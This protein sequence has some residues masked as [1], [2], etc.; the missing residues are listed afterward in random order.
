MIRNINYFL[1]IYCCRI[2][3]VGR[4][5]PLHGEGRRFKSYI[6]HHLYGEVMLMV[7]NAAVNRRTGV[8]FPYF[9]PNT[10]L[11]Q[12]GEHLLDVQKVIGSTPIRST[13]CFLRIVERLRRHPLKVERWVQFSLRRPYVADMIWYDM[14]WYEMK[15][16][17]KKWFE[18]F[19]MVLFLGNNNA[20][21][22]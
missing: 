10:V 22:V 12:L 11:A 7:G 13:I 18:D 9:P 14:R 19:F 1:T 3:S 16:K 15:R 6:R 20:N 5:A 17:S 21:R 2:S 8:Q 4:V